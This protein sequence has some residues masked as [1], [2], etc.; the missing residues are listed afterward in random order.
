MGILWFM[1]ECMFLC[2]S[3]FVFM[4]VVVFTITFV[5]IY[6]TVKLFVFVL[7]HIIATRK[8]ART[9]SSAWTGTW[10]FELPLLTCTSSFS[11]RFFMHIVNLAQCPYKNIARFT[12]LFSL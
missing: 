8:E 4:L 9:Q 2:E 6:L 10:F 7:L 3:M 5:L 1:H 11:C 12:I